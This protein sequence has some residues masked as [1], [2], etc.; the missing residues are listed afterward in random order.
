MAASEPREPTAGER[1]IEGVLII[2]NRLPGREP[3]HI[4]I[5]VVIKAISD[6][7]QDIKLTRHLERA[8]YST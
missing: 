1:S 3:W 2:T 7:H 5:T 4:F 6:Y 8:D